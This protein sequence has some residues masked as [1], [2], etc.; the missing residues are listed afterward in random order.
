MSGC[1]TIEQSYVSVLK[2]LCAAAYHRDDGGVLAVQLVE[3]DVED[4]GGDAVHEGDDA[5]EHVELGGAGRALQQVHHVG[6][7][8]GPR[9]HR[10]GEPDGRQ[11]ANRE[12]QTLTNDC[13]RHE[14]VSNQ[15]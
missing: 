4:E 5:D 6:V 8:V 7:V 1:S 15:A 2:T 10:D 9:A 11:A 14:H 12:T 13:R 3:E